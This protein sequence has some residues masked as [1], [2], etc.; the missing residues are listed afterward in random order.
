LLCD[1]HLLLRL[2]L[3]AR[4]APLLWL[5]TDKADKALRGT[6]SNAKGLKSLQVRH[7]VPQLSLQLHLLLLLPVWLLG[8]GLHLLL[9]LLVVVAF[10][11][12]SHCLLN[13]WF[14]HC[15]CSSSTWPSN[16]C[17]SSTAVMFLAALTSLSTTRC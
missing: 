1:S 12:C 14:R 15:C 17:F 8:R 5:G 10:Q 7:C 11:H 3:L 13:A 2:L 6:S 16:S 9:L 4:L